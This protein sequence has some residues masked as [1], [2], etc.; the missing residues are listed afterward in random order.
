MQPG[1]QSKIANVL[2]TDGRN[3]KLVEPLTFVTRDGRVLI[4]PCGAAT[5]GASTP[6]GTWDVLPPFG[7]YWLAALLHDAAYQNTLQ[8]PDGTLA[9]LTKDQSDALLLEA[10]QSL[11][12]N[13]FDAQTI[14]NGVHDFGWKAFKDDR[15]FRS[16]TIA[17][18]GGLG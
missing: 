7:D 11:G 14:Y 5:D 4:I 13:N 9:T 3:C 8:L 18:I 16:A 12:V 15:S 6:Q 17:T 10:M 1:F 2:T